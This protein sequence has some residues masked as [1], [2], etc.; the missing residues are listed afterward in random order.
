MVIAIDGPAGTGKSTVAHAVAKD[1]GIVYL[2]SGSFYRALTLAAIDSGIDLNDSDAVMDFARKQKL[3]YV[4]A[5]LI[6]NGKDVED[7]LHQDKVDS[8]VSQVSSI[9]PLRHLVNDR[10]REI[11]KSLS[12]ICEGRDMTTVVFPNAEYKFYLDASI[13]VQ[14]KRRFDQGVS[15]LSLE[16][17]KAAIIKRDEMDRN[18]AEGSLK[19]AKD[20]VYIDTSDLT[21][22]QVCEII[23]SN[24]T[25]KGYNMEQKEVELNEAQD[26]SNIH[27]QL[28]ASL[29]KI[30]S[31]ESG[32]VEGTVVEVR[33]DTVFVDVGTGRDGQ[34][35]ISEFGGE[36]PNVGDKITVFVRNPSGRDGLPDISKLMAD[37]KRLWEE[38]SAAY[39]D[40]TAVD[41]TIESL[42]K[43]GY[44]VDLGGGIKA[45]LPI[46]QADS[47]KVEKEEKLLGLKGKFYI[48]RLFS[49]KK[50]NV[51]VN[52]RKYL[53]EQ[54]DV[55][56]DKFFNEIKIGDTVKGTVKSFTSFGAFIDLGGFDGLLHINDMSWGHVTRP[57]DFVKKGQE[58]ELKVI[59][60]DPEGK[61]I[62]L[63]LKHFT[64]D[65]W[66]H[67]EEKYHVNDVVTGKVTKLTDFGAFIELEE[68]IEGLAHI[69]EFSWT[70]KINK[71]SDMVKEG[72][73]V[74]CMILGYDIQA[75]RVSLGLKQV[76]DNPWDTISEKYPV[77]TKVKGKVVKITNSGAFVQLEEGIDAFLSGEDLSWTKKVKHP[78]SEIK[79]DQ[80][81][82][83]IVIECD[84]ENHRIRVGVKQLTDNPWKEFANEYKPGSTLEGEVSSIQDFGIFVKAPNGIE[85]LVNKANLSEDRE[86][87]YE[88][89]VKKYNVGDKVNVYVVS[90]DVAKEKVAFS[91][92]E[93]KKAQARA[94]ISQYMSSSADDD[95]A[96]TIG[97]SLKIQNK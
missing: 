24:L 31:V 12:V 60:L 33:D 28:E 34:L 21:I 65:P 73:E 29:N 3:D 46:S 26:S 76:T 58:I 57:K 32:N 8:N 17:I 72:D 22:N 79:V 84:P 59:R 89:A 92:K 16:E 53:E 68:G 30:E 54:I 15:S 52:R 47:Q 39:K 50:R 81:L 61:R 41:G 49:N 1:L 48:E 14:A 36:V 20:A 56:R 93:Y 25:L 27:A 63:S 80:E 37:E 23:K 2:N 69:S 77:D 95:S 82:D 6:L 97:D 91:V 45:F 7:K 62:N 10:M 4:N 40:K 96:Y 87:P 44:M 5:H 83:V 13:D 94:E 11:V 64:E 90:V 42:T 9:V 88:E 71:P 74:Q 35:R 78:G 55:N 70:K 75:G 51:V 66:V 18:K 43:G 85:G 19:K 38:F 86:T 67:F